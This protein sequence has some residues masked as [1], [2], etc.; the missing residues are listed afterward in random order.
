M[1]V[2]MTYGRNILMERAGKCP[3]LFGVCGRGQ[4]NHVSGLGSQQ[5][6]DSQENQCC[7]E[8][9]PRAET[10]AALRVSQSDTQKAEGRKD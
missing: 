6:A 5:N 1:S 4:L 7:W 10:N 9:H 8:G 2:S 3:V